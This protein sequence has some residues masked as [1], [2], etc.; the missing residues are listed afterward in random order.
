[1]A[2]NKKAWIFGVVVLVLII[3]LM[4]ITQKEPSKSEIKSESEIKIG[5]NPTGLYAFPLFIAQEKGFF[6]DQDLKVQLKQME[7]TVVIPA[8]LAKEIDY[9]AFTLTGVKAGLSGAPVKI[10][11]ALTKSSFFALIAQPNLELND[12]KS[13]G[14]TTWLSPG[15]YLALKTIEENNLPAEI[16]VA[17]SI[18]GAATLLITG[19]VDALIHD[20][21]TAYRLQEEGYP[22]LKIFDDQIPQGLVTSD[23]KIENNPGEVEKMVKAIQASSAFIINNPQETQELLFSFLKLERN[24]TNQKII[25]NL[26]SSLKQ[27]VN[28][29]ALLSEKETNTLI[30]FSKASDFKTFEDIEK[31]EV[32]EEDIAKVFDLRF[33]K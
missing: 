17:E 7:P 25:E 9:F 16:K 1:M 29:T 10:I 31:Q 23:E 30:R 27:N 19:Q 32:T 14:I 24:E 20:I 3:T 5:Y 26:Y 6:S 13:I 33:V 22:I 21:V 15:H 12:L 8:L 18:P 28:E 4:I 2:I 11:M